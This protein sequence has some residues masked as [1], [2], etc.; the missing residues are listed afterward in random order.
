MRT[1]DRA[2][3]VDQRF[4]GSG[5]VE[6]QAHVLRDASLQIAALD[7]GEPVEQ[8]RAARAAF[9]RAEKFSRQ[10]GAFGLGQAAERQHAWRLERRATRHRQQ[11]GLHLPPPRQAASRCA[12][13]K[14]IR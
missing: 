1:R 8:C 13:G 3:R 10:R 12:T 4:I 6:Q 11:R 2:R 7:R 14:R 9:D 5:A